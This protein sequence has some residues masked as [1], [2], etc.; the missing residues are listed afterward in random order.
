MNKKT[1]N[2]PTLVGIPITNKCNFNCPHCL[3][4][5]IKNFDKEWEMSVAQAKHLAKKFEG[6]AK[7]I[8]CSA[9][10]GEPFLNENICEILEIF[11]KSKLKTIVYTNGSKSVHER[12]LNSFSDILLISFDKYH[13]NSMTT[14]KDIIGL[15]E[16]ISKR[17]V[18][19]KVILTCV[20]DP[21]V[22]ESDIVVNAY[23]LCKEYDFLFVEFHWRFHYISKEKN[24]VLQKYKDLFNV[25]ESDR[26]EKPILTHFDYNHCFDIYN[27][28]YFDHEGFVRRCCVFYDSIKDINIFTKNLDEIWDSNQLN[29]YRKKF[30]CDDGFEECK[31]CPIG[32]G[33]II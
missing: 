28:L 7:F 24:V 33:Y 11:R 32:F 1:L 29:D 5:Q 12:I 18:S 30:F 16:K 2:Y 13:N 20:I 21:Y 22:F 4:N 14:N 6:K 9:G 26:F 15:L 25:I 23:E 10:Y 19:N 3:R 27:S 31:N 17:N 8:N